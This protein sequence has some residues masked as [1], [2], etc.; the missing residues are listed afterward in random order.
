[1]IP[2]QVS[3]SGVTSSDRRHERMSPAAGEAPSLRQCRD[4]PAIV[5]VEMWAMSGS[6]QDGHG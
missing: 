4:G 2:D 3:T 6:S 1:M 5:M